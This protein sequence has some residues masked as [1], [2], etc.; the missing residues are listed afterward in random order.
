MLTIIRLGW[1]INYIRYYCDRWFYNVGS[2]AN[3]NVQVGN[4][5]EKVQSE[6]DSH[7]KSRGRKTKL[8]ITYYNVLIP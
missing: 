3:K 7:T 4:D 6:K 8:T 2:M 5:Q 1:G